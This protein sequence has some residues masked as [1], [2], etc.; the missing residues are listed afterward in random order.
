MLLDVRNR[1]KPDIE[2]ME[3]PFVVF[4][5]SLF[6]FCNVN[7][8]GEAFYNGYFVAY[9]ANVVPEYPI[10]IVYYNDPQEPREQAVVYNGN[11][12]ISAIGDVRRSP[13]THFVEVNNLAKIP[14]GYSCIATIDEI[15]KEYTS[16]EVNNITD[17]S[18][19][20]LLSTGTSPTDLLLDNDPSTYIY[21]TSGNVTYLARET[22]FFPSLN[23]LGISGL[24]FYIMAY[25]TDAIRK[26]NVE[27]NLSSD[28]NNWITYICSITLQEEKP[29]GIIIKNPVQFT[30]GSL[31]DYRI[32]R[33]EV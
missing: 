10:K 27:I 22:F 30:N 1:Y 26:N 32:K 25:N 15:N 4:Y 11:R 9:V 3:P 19:E 13:R 21:T 16:Y 6:D 20:W 23:T 33:V 17:S 31:I 2:Y 5:D 28:I 14:P 8:A 7:Y 18:N 12:V 29:Y 24:S